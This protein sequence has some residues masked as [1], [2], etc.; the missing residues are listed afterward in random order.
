MARKLPSGADALS[1][2]NLR[3]DTQITCRYKAGTSDDA[4]SSWRLIDGWYEFY[5]ICHDLNTDQ[6]VD[7]WGGLDFTLTGF[8][9]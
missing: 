6:E 7:F 1:Q 9:Y 4:V 3:G 2:S 8:F 5:I